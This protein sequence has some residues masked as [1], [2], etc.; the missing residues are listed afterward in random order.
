VAGRD[1]ATVG[2]LA[3]RGARLL[4]PWVSSCHRG[5]Q[6]QRGNT[7]GNQLT[8]R[9]LSTGAILRR[10]NIHG[11]FSNA[12]M[13]PGAVPRRWPRAAHSCTGVYSGSCI[14]LNLETQALARMARATMAEID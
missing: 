14:A 6:R 4:P 5:F 13:R 1:D 8:S 9:A 10:S 3:D 12:A 11:D 2:A 7:A